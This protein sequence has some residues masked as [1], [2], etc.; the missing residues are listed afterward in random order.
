MTKLIIY[1][2]ITVFKWVFRVLRYCRFMFGL[3]KQKSGQDD[4]GRVK[5][6]VLGA[7]RATAQDIID[8]QTNVMVKFCA[9][10]FPQVSGVIMSSMER[11]FRIEPQQKP[12]LRKYIADSFLTPPSLNQAARNF[13]RQLGG[14]H[15]DAHRAI[16]QLCAIAR[17]ADRIARAD[18]DRIIKLAKALGLTQGEILQL[19]QRARLT[20]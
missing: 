11:S 15:S 5:G 19:F 9:Y 18:L 14:G 3:M 16:S 13:K 4:M 12:E 1:S 17:S 7:M 6:A 20:A 2:F 8:P 10:A